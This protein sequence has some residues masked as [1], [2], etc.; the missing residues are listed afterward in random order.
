MTPATGGPRSG[1]PESRVRVTSRLHL[2]GGNWRTICVVN[3][4]KP[5]EWKWV[6]G[7]LAALVCL[8]GL[9]TVEPETA[10]A[11]NTTIGIGGIGCVL[12]GIWQLMQMDR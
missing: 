3:L 11:V 9:A 12:W 4:L 7:L 2:E 1:T 5:F 8:C 10:E 6:W